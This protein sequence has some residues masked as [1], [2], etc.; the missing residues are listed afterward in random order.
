MTIIDVSN[1]WSRFKPVLPRLKFDV[2]V[3]SCNKISNRY[4]SYVNIDYYTYTRTIFVVSASF[5]IFDVPN[6]ASFSIRRKTTKFVDDSQFHKNYE[7]DI[8]RNTDFQTI[9]I[10]ILL[11]TRD[12]LSVFV[13]ELDIH[14]YWNSRRI[15]IYVRT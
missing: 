6:D 9:G 15:K 5:S 7:F 10:L 12:R 11:N 14:N 4:L 13:G 8:F 3:H 2:R 1:T